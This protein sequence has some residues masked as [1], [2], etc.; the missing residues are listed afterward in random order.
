MSR[1]ANGSA[2]GRDGS[3]KRHM[4]SAD[5]MPSLPSHVRLHHD[6][7]RGRWV[8]LAPE[9]LLEPDEAALDT[10]KLCDG[11]TTVKSISERLSEEYNAPAE[12]ILEDILAMLQDLADKDFLRA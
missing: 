4:V 1:R 8:L 5:S 6:E 2:P 7:T 12:R 3:R 10:L 11:R 9:R